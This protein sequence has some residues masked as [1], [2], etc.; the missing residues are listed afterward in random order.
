MGKKNNDNEKSSS[1]GIKKILI[2]IVAL[3]VLGA[4][5]FG[6][7]Y[8]YM[9][10]SNTQDKPIVEVKVPIC[11][12]M[13]IKLS[14]ESGNRYVKATVNISYDKNNK[15]VGKEITD[16]TIEIKDRTLFYLMSKKQEDYRASNE[17][18]LKKGL[19]DEVNKL[20][21]EGKVLNVYFD[22]LLTQ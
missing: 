12:D 10:N 2:V 9:Q 20:L 6:G 8:F 19:I 4:G 7:V 21:D 16:K 14:D 1:G 18:N 17:E 22:Q 15:K 5:G 3:I 13:T 11:E